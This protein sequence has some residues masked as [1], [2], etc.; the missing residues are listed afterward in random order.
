MAGRNSGNGGN[1]GKSGRP[2]FMG[3]FALKAHSW[4]IMQCP[5]SECVCLLF[6][7]MKAERGHTILPGYYSR[8][9]GIEGR[10]ERNLHCH[11]FSPIMP[12]NMPT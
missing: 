10:P 6:F 2:R 12:K 9:G 11:D 3:R 5:I 7:A 4:D 1:S 8:G